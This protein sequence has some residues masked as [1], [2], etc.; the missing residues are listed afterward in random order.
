[1]NIFFSLEC[2]RPVYVKVAEAV[3]YRTF[4]KFKSISYYVQKWKKINF[5]K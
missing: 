5:K 3:S 2:Y 1:M 4:I